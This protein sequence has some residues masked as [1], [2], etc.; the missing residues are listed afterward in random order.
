M[1]GTAA[2]TVPTAYSWRSRWGTVAGWVSS[3]E[4]SSLSLVMVRE[5][6]RAILWR[7]RWSRRPLWSSWPSRLLPSAVACAE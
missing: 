5:V 1:I 2:Q 4:S 7:E 6:R 3:R